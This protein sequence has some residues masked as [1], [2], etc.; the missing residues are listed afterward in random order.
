MHVPYENSGDTPKIL[1]DTNDKENTRIIIKDSTGEN[2][3]KTNEDIS[4]WPDSFLDISVEDTTEIMD[5]KCLK[6]V[7]KKFLTLF[8]S[9]QKYLNKKIRDHVSS[10]HSITIDLFNEETTDGSSGSGV[11]SLDFSGSSSASSNGKF[12]YQ[13][14]TINLGN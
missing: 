4:S 9:L 5:R 12:L 8:L 13:F 2:D 14:V 6:S 10:I 1:N 11:A 7:I 3:P